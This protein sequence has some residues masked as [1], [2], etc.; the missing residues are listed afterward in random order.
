RPTYREMPW[1]SAALRRRA[2]TAQN[3]WSSIPHDG[4]DRLAGMHQVESLVDPLERQNVRD[5]IVDVYPAVH[6]PVDDSR[7]VGS[8]ARA[9]E[10]R[11]FPCS[12]GNQLEWPRADLLAGARDSDDDR[13]TPAAVGAF[14][15]LTHDIDVADA[16][17][18]VVGTATGQYDK[19]RNQVGP[20]R[21]RVDEMGQPELARQRLSTWIDVD[22]DDHVGTGD[23]RPLN[24]IQP[25]PAQT[26][27]DDV[28]SGFH[29]GGVDHRT[30]AGRHAAA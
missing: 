20:R 19:V 24:D 27:H 16:F 7:Q 23:A 9:S 10:C 5:Q 11:A 22:A 29:F 25:D 14:Q 30:D 4:A 17:E 13:D 18:R 2:P 8:A 6:V 1:R 12:A 15:R 21:A 3:W 26:E 28:R